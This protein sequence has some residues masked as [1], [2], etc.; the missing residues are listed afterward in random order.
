MA[1]KRKRRGN[2]EG[3]IFQRADGQ[4]TATIAIGHDANGKRKRRTVYGKTRGEVAEK[5][6]RLQGQKLDGTLCDDE[7]L[8]V[9]EYLPRWLED[10]ARPTIKENTY[11][12]YETMIRV[13]IAKHIGGVKLAKLSPAHVQGMYSVM[14]RGGASGRVRLLCHA[15]LR[16][17]LKQAVRWQLVIRNVC[18]AVDP[19][20]VEKREIQP[21]TVEQSQKLLAEVRGD[22][23][24]A[25]YVL[26][27]TAGLRQGELLGLKWNDIDLQAGTVS[28][29]RTLRLKAGRVIVT[30][31]KSAKGRRLVELP[32]M[33][34]DAIQ[35]HRKRMLADGHAGCEWVFCNEAGNPVDK[36]NL[37]RRSFKPTLKRAELPP[38]RFH[39][40]RHTHATLLLLQGEHP[41]V[42][43]ERLGHAN[44]AMTLDIYSHVLPS[45]Q[46]GAADRLGDMF[47]TESA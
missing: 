32:S 38:I 23:M 30:S 19:P 46:R 9:G 25:V 16:R 29:Q 37:V 44:I 47:R 17:S 39:D 27:L 2:N 6:T 13:H 22:R 12:N 45:M 21:L 41:E 8:T 28:V 5:L 11:D 3:S 34:V 14:E 35:D 43:Q 24:E 40:L 20:K 31:P 7:R 18:D 4:W 10:S 33:T 15:V 36:N 1:K 26:A 42:V